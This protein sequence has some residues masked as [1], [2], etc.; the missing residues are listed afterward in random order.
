M[1]KINDMKKFAV[2]CF[3]IAGVLFSGNADAQILRLG[4]DGLLFGEDS[5]QTKDVVSAYSQVSVKKKKRGYVTSGLFS[6]SSIRSVEYGWNMVK[7]EDPGDFFDLYNWG[8]N[9]ITV[10]PIGICATNYRHTFD[11]SMAIG[12]RAN[13][14]MFDENITIEKVGGSVYPVPLVREVKKSKF[15]TAAIHVP[16]ELTFGKPSRLALSVGGFADINFNSHTKVKYAKGPKSKVHRFPVNFLQTGL[17]AKITLKSLSFYCNWYP[18]GVFE[19]GKGP[20]MQI[21]SFGIGI[22]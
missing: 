11:F 4:V 2:L 6:G 1:K 8:S 16:V 17:S 3:V 20:K 12:I 9:Q 14:Y 7:R 21:W 22:L 15:T 10:N 19:D 5:T 18:G 13:N